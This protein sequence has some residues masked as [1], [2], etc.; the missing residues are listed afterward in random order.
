MRINLIVILVLISFLSFG[1]GNGLYRFQTENGKY[2]FM[3]KT[4]KIIIKPKYLEVQD[5]SEGLCF[6]SKEL[7]NNDYKWICIDTLGVEV[8][9]IKDCFPE[10]SFKEGFAR[11]S[12]FD[13]NWFIDHKGKNVFNKTFRDGHGKFSDGYALVSENKYGDKVFIDI[14]GNSPAQLPYKN[15]SSFKNGLS[16]YYT[17]E[18]G[19]TLFDTSGTILMTNLESAEGLYDELIRVKKNGKCGFIDRKGN[20]LI[21][22]QY[23]EDRIRPMDKFL[24][25][26]TDS[27]DALP[28]A[29][30]RNV[31]LFS[32]GLAKIQIDGLWGFINTKNELVIDPKFKK[33]LSFSDGLAGVSIDGVLWGFI[34]TNGHFTIQPKYFNVDEFKNGV[35]GVRLEFQINEIGN[36]YLLD[37]LI[38]TKGEILYNNGMHCYMG[39]QGDLIQ[40][41][42]GRDFSGGVYYLNKNGREVIPKE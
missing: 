19:I 40:F 35:C 34:D 16:T 32:N 11:I 9:D 26:N 21:D 7:L 1:Q 41:Y 39:F 33:A 14:H 18:S 37:A 28:K 23:E 42:G 38:N 29:K 25:L 36:D 24:K 13:A 5:F 12:D 31:G 2:G 22:F 4:G 15:A 10:T 3:N 27:L 6:V 20:I 8:F 17:K 30:S